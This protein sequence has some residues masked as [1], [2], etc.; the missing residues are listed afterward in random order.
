MNKLVAIVYPDQ[1]R[2]AEVFATLHRMQN[3]ELIDI[4][5]AVYVTRDDKGKV[6]LHQS[7][8]LTG[9]GALVGSMW[10]LLIGMLFLSPVLGAA[11]GAA[12]GAAVGGFSD[13]GIDDKFMKE[14]GKKMKNDT[15]ALFISFR[16]VVAD[17][18]VPEISQ[19]GGE[20]IQTSLSTKTEKKL[21]EALDKGQ[22]RADY[23]QIAA[24]A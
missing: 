14:L 19:Y 3:E 15:S 10:G 24:G 9:E 11:I 17:K 8:S 7:S 18:V 13:Y 2:A 6:K 16:S 21:Q 4:E 23:G 1:S 20:I 5:D 22:L 12:G